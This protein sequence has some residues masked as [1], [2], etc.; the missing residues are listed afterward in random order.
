MPAARLRVSTAA[1]LVL[2]LALLYSWSGG[3]VSARQTGQRLLSYE[4]VFGATA[5]GPRGPELL[6]E[7]P[8]VIGWA[9]DERYLE[10][11]VDPADQQRKVYAVNVSDGRAAI[12]RDYAAIQERLPAGFDPRAAATT[13]EDLSGFVFNRDNDLYHYDVATSRFRRLTATPA[14]ERNPRFSPN[15]RWVAYTRENNLFAYDLDNAIEYQ[16]TTDGSD[17]VYNGWASW[18]YYEEILGRASQY[19]AFWWS[20]DSAQLAF[21]RFDDS[22]VPVFPIHHADG[23][24][25]ELERQRYPKAGDPNPW[26]R[27]GVVPVTGGP[28]VWMDFQEKAD[29]YIAWPFWTRDSA[30][31]V[32]QW[33]N[34]GQDTI[35]FYNCDPATGKKTQVFEE[36][37]PSWVR[38]FTDLHYFP[39][40]SFLLR[41]DVDGWDHLYLHG[42]DGR[43]TRRL[44]SGD[45]RVASIARVDEGGGW[46]Y[47]VA[48]PAGRTWDAHLMRVRLAGAGLQQLTPGDG[49]HSVRVS[50]GGRHF[51]TTTSTLTA[52][53]SMALYRSDGTRVRTLGDAGSPAMEAYA[54]GRAELFTIP[55]GDGY[56]LPAFWVL[57]PDFDA[58]R[59]YPVIFSIYGGPDAGRVRNAWPGL[60]AHYWAQRGIITVGVDH[61]GSGHFG[62]KGVALMHRRLGHWEMTDLITAATWVR[63]KPFVDRDKVAVTGG[64][65][66]G[67]VTMLALTY[68]A[69]H[70]NYGQ[71]SASVTDWRLYDTVYTER[72]MDTP[73]ENPEGYEHGAV[74]TWIDRYRGGLRITHGTIDDNVHMQNSVQVI[75]WLTANDRSFELM[76]YPNSRHGIR[77]AQRAHALREA[78]DFWVRHLLDGRLPKGETTASGPW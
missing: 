78:H 55:S 27:M 17:T 39:D 57:P 37:Q 47:F 41:T 62:K 65:Y 73:Q 20:P 30:T 45:W 5:R 12:H 26:V 44:T 72:Y 58:S 48:R 1:R 2:P 15:G 42:P 40:G 50:P 25:G 28:V 75:D 21:M 3:A 13:T 14:P 11:R 31:L 38:F 4:E 22:P 66:G 60:D 74:L 64:S 23:Q 52:P 53:P 8:G 54:W 7:L 34:R 61:R 59:R 67:Y 49:T 19:A 70:F 56:D 18:V 24:H 36:R 71:A 68:G 76:I 6:A 63:A 10:M 32:V 77:A 9:D 16:Y 29:H 69:E 33:M 46:V 43:L 51:I 35:R